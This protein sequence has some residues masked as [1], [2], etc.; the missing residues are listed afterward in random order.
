MLSLRQTVLLVALS[1]MLITEMEWYYEQ[2]EKIEGLQED[3]EIVGT[4]LRARETE[5]ERLGILGRE[6]VEQ[7]EK[8]KMSKRTYIRECREYANKYDTTTTTTGK[9]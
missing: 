3:M 5:L 7:C 9:Q 1:I 2:R 4:G 6:A 8:R